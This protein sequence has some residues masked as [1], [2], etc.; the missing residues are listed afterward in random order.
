MKQ[1]PNKTLSQRI[2]EK[3]G[4][5]T[6]GPRGK[7]RAEVLQALPEIK[8][9]LVDGWSLRTIWRTLV[10]EGR[11]HMTYNGFIGMLQRTPRMQGHMKG[12]T[13]GPQE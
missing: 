9:A 1:P 11:I 4:K 10:D 8:D 6:Y 13:G 2:R 12:T 5:Q 7:N 3:A